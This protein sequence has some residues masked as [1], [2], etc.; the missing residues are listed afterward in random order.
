MDVVNNDSVGEPEKCQDDCIYPSGQACIGKQCVGEG[1][2]YDKYGDHGCPTDK[3][4]RLVTLLG[5]LASNSNHPPIYEACVTT[6]VPIIQG[7]Y[8]HEY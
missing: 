1:Q 3:A 7:W 4:H 6:M 8:E 2:P 5:P